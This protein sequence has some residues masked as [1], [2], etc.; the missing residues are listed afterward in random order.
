MS[1][2]VV[3]VSR[4]RGR[5][6]N[7]RKSCSIVVGV[8]LI[9]VQR[10]HCLIPVGSHFGL[11]G[12]TIA[13]IVIVVCSIIVIVV[14]IVVSTQLPSSRVHVFTRVTLCTIELE[15]IQHNVQVIVRVAIISGIIT[16]AKVIVRHTVIGVSSIIS[17]SISS[18]VV[19]VSRSRGRI[20]NLRKSCSIVVGV[21][22]IDVQREERCI[23]IVHELGQWVRAAIRA[24]LGTMVAVVIIIVSSIVI[25]E[26]VIIECVVVECIIVLS[27]IIIIVK[28]GSSILWILDDLLFT[29][30]IILLDSR[31]HMV[32]FFIAIL[33]LFLFLYRSNGIQFLLE[34]TAHLFRALARRTLNTGTVGPFQV[35]ELC[36]QTAGFFFS[37][38]GNH[39][40]FGFHC[41]IWHTDIRHLDYILPNNTLFVK[42]LGMRNVRVAGQ[43]LGHC[44]GC[45][46]AKGT[47]SLTACTS[48]NKGA[49]YRGR[50]THTPGLV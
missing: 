15:C 24:A 5:I 12:D 30:K 47:S 8:G 36:R 40:V 28:D 19:V 50:H 31:V 32:L 29:S 6:A 43:R 45:R 22:L 35:Q 18:I 20:A 7:F 21:G 42:S 16:K 2:I 4:S 34:T 26:S 13:A 41:P 11:V 46:A 27:T 38:I 1:S 25:V 44:F 37:T 49:C 39:D 33:L 9:D 14:I 23:P 48:K 10:E 3:V 17:V